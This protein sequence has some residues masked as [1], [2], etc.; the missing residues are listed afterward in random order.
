MTH[1]TMQIRSITY[2]DLD[3]IVAMG[4]RMHA[5]SD[6]SF[7]PYCYDKVKGIL[8]GYLDDGRGK[9]VRIVTSGG[10]VPVAVLGGMMATYPF[11]TA[12]IAK[13][14]IFFVDVSY[15]GSAAAMMLLQAFRT[16]A[17]ENE[18]AEICLSVS[19][20][21]HTD[22]TGRFYERMGLRYVGGIYKHRLR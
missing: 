2:E 8:I 19:S 16:W 3:D 9:F 22:R 15:R 14:L 11:C 13:D 1:T 10:G 18:A 5:E 6:Y 7:L 21:V 4:A 12:K 17:V 20:G